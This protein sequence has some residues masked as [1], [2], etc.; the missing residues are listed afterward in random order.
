MHFKSSII[1]LYLNLIPFFLSVFFSLFLSSSLSMATKKEM[2]MKMRV[3]GEKAVDDQEGRTATTTTI[4]TTIITTTVITTAKVITATTAATAITMA[5]ASK[6]DDASDPSS[7]HLHQ[8]WTLM[9]A[10]R[11]WWCI[12]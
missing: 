9:M 10:R 11:R 4:T 7:S 12:D 1:I 2:M 5:M 3:D 6:P 8:R